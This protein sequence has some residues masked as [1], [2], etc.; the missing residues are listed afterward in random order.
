MILQK[1]AAKDT[2][3]ALPTDA[4]QRAIFPRRAGLAYFLSCLQLPVVEAKFQVCEKGHLVQRHKES[5][6]DV[7][8]T[9]PDISDDYTFDYFRRQ[10]PNQ[11]H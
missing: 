5:N 4:S 1:S 7:T 11:A 10:F 3:S 8:D 9:R 2:G 6:S